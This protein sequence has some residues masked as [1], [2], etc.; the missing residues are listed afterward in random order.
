MRTARWPTAGVARLVRSIR[1]ITIPRW[2]NIAHGLQSGTIIKIVRRITTLRP[3]TLIAVGVGCV[4]AVASTEWRKVI[5][6]TGWSLLRTIHTTVLKTALGPT[7]DVAR[8]V[9]SIRA[10]TISGHTNVTHG[11]Q[12]GTMKIVRFIATLRIPT[13]ITFCIWC[14]GA[15]AGAKGVNRTGW[16]DL[17]TVHST[18]VRTTRWPTIGV[19]S[20]VGSVGA[21]TVPG[22]TNIAH[23]LFLGALKIIGRVAT[24][25]PTTLVTLGVRR[26][27]AVARTRGRT[28]TALSSAA[29]TRWLG[30]YWAVPRCFIA[31]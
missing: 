26:V 22:W 20:F 21:I 12:G 10:I 8:F 2:S 31:A 28:T 19:A 4:G 27:S 29:I 15:V 30:T 13:L 25:G 11:L 16:F 5:N 17:G 24:L 18:I 7:L 1:A 14:I 23:G 3:S 6:R 9:R